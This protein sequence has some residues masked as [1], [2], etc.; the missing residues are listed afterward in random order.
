MTVK[1]K[2]L[3]GILISM[4]LFTGLFCDKDHSTNTKQDQI[5]CIDVHSQPPYPELEENVNLQGIIQDMDENNVSLSI[6][7]ARVKMQYSNEVAAF[8]EAN[9][10][11]I[12]AAVS[13]KLESMET[14]TGFINTLAAQ[15]AT[16]K[17]NAIAE[18][19]LYHAQKFDNTGKS[20]A[21]EFME[22]PNSELVKTLINT[23]AQL[24]CP[25]ILHIEF[26]SLESKYGTAL[27]NQYMNQ[28]KQLLTTYT[29]QQF[30]LTH[31]AELNPAECRDL[32]D[33]YQNIFFTTNFM[34]LEILMTGEPVTNY[35]ED[36]WNTLLKD[37]P[38]RFVFAFDRVFPQQ[39]MAYAKDMNY[40]QEK[41]LD[42]PTSVAEAIAYDN[43]VLLFGLE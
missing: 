9:P 11:R 14:D 17:F 8:A 19:L 21:P 1:N 6:L 26:V 31:V 13:L 20:T 33:N 23:C 30:V 43:A 41:L 25:V 27:R 40:A 24:N 29:N 35:S 42:L 36:D 22:N 3:F 18:M 32:I 7:S 2:I 38:D 10:D 37:H 15:V 5:T 16:G 34:D 12:I 4:I 28:L 39:W